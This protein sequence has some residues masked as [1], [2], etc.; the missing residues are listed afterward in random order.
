MKLDSQ[1]TALAIVIL[2]AVIVLIAALRQMSDGHFQ[3]LLGFAGG[4]TTGA[5]ALVQSEKKSDPSDPKA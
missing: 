1:K 3:G 5:F 4:L 2:A